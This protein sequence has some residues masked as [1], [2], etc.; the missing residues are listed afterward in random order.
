CRAK[1]KAAYGLAG[2]T[3]Q[4][5][6]PAELA[7]EPYTWNEIISSTDDSNLRI[8]D[9]AHTERCP[10]AI[11][12]MTLTIKNNIDFKNTI[13]DNRGSYPI[14][15]KREIELKI[16]GYTQNK[17]LFDFWRGTW[18]NTTNIMSGATTK[19]SAHL[20]LQRTALTDLMD[21]HLY[22]LTVEEHGVD[23]YSIDDSIWAVD[24]TLTDAT[25][26]LDGR[27]IYFT[28]IGSTTYTK[29]YYHNTDEV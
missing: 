5:S 28:T 23:L 9:E 10:A 2:G 11:D 19:L 13:G 12:K 4:N 20:R 6:P 27:Q 26:D 7:L 16:T 15:H 22:N 17:E 8:L 3:A 29:L 14:S 24:I 25:A 1:C 18:D 21:I